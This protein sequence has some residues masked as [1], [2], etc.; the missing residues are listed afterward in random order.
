MTR[1]N[2]IVAVYNS[3]KW[4][5]KNLES[6]AS[7]KY[8]NWRGVVI[9][10]A[11]TNNTQKIISRNLP[12]KMISI[13]NTT[14]EGALHNQLIG[15]EKLGCEDEDVI[16]IIDG[17]DWLPDAYTFDRLSK[18][19]Q[20]P[21]V[22]LTYG[23]YEIY[24]KNRISDKTRPATEHDNPRTGPMIYRHLRTFKYFLWKNI[25]NES[26]LDPKTGKHFFYGTDSV[27]MRPMVEMAGLSH[28]KHIDD[29]MY[30]YNFTEPLN[31]RKTQLKLHNV[32][33]GVIGRQ[34]PYTVK[35]KKELVQND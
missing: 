15:V 32:C 19:Y 14:R 21:E 20:D 29:K 9:D 34:E 3:E 30:V 4:I 13:F 25:K 2:V 28:I 22:W 26:L 24:P 6:L 5:I 1:F 33:C 10:D 16:V 12:N 11:S 27:V 7:Q 8:N 31:S 18:V 23:S 35:T 17:D